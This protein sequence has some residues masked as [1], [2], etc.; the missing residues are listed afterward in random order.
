MRSPCSDYVD[1]DAKGSFRRQFWNCLCTFDF[2]GWASL[3]RSPLVQLFKERDIDEKM[4]TSFAVIGFR[5][6]GVVILRNFCKRYS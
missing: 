5:D 4:F 1:S 2:F 3:A 6:H